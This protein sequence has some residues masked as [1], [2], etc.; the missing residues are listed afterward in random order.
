MIDNVVL[1]VFK[2]FVEALLQLRLVRLSLVIV[3]DGLVMVA[4]LCERRLVGR[5]RFRV[6]LVYRSAGSDI[7]SCVCFLIDKGLQP[8]HLELSL[9]LRDESLSLA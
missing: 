5:L 3:R 2:V 1:K 9:H 8:L 7:L 4:Q 6:H